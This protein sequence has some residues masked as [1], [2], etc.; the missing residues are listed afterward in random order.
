M[1][2]SRTSLSRVE[3]LAYSTLIIGIIGDHLSTSIALGI[4]NVREANPMA[5]GLMQQNLWIQ[6]D[7]VLII[8]SIAA[9]FTTLRIVKNPMARATLILPI[10]VGLLRLVVKFFNVYIII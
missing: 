7:L 2:L 5:S 6:T 9:T 8:I 1:M 4:G 10:M 3:L